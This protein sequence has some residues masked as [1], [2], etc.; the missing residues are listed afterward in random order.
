MR[1]GPQLC[2]YAKFIVESMWLSWSIMKTFICNL[3]RVLLLRSSFGIY[4]LEH[5]SFLCS[6]HTIFRS[7]LVKIR[8]SCKRVGPN[9]EQKTCPK[10][11][12]QITFFYILFE[13]MMIMCMF[14]KIPYFVDM[15][16]APSIYRKVN[17]PLDP[18]IPS[19]HHPFTVENNQKN[20]K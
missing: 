11:G 9:V 18:S 17:W 1:N 16:R 2:P 7:S 10:F 20:L 13:S 14:F 15:V 6:F 8:D 4:A 3:K 19:V 5:I 12:I